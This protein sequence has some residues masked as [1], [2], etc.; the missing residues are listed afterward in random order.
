M[1][2]LTSTNNLIWKP[3]KTEHIIQDSWIDFRRMTYT[4]PDGT[5]SGP[6]YNYSRRSY[7]V[8]VPFDENGNLICVK[9]FRYGIGAVTTEFPAGGIETGCENE[10]TTQDNEALE[11]AFD[12]AKRELKEETGYVSDSWEHLITVPSN[13]TM[14][15]NYAYIFKAKNCRHIS[16][17]HL[18]DTEFLNVEKYSPSEIDDLIKTGRFQQAMHIMA[19][20]ISKNAK[21]SH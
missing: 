10:Y 15:D 14:S 12:A 21:H 1:K 2:N 18:D 16:E 4:L 9:Q 7:A 6:Y 3:V 5:V 19:W 17:Q 13:A 8:I 20:Y 11:S